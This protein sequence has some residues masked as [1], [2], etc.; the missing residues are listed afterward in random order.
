MEYL[1]IFLINKISPY[2]LIACVASVLSLAG[3]RPHIEL[4]DSLNINQILSILTVL[5]AHLGL[6]LR[7]KE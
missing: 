6:T 3:F 5:F 7:D 1:L 4:S 2:E